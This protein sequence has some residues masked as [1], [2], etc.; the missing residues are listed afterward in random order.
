MIDRG[1]EYYVRGLNFVLRHPR[2]TIA[3][4]FSLLAASILLISPVIRREFFPEVDGGAFQ[5][6]VRAPSG[7]RIEVTE[8]RIKAVEDYLRKS[9]GDDLELFISELGVTPDWS[10]AYTPNA[11]PMDAIVRVQ[12]KEERARSAQKAAADVR[13]GLTQDPAF[14]D[15]EFSFDT[16]GLIRGA[17]NEGKSTPINIRVTGKNQAR[18]AAEVADAMRSRVARVDGIVDARVIQRLN[19]PEFIVNVDRAKAADLGLTQ[20]DARS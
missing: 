4:G 2:S 8:Q 15:L 13:E 3:V 7:T 16:G 18:S 6:T 12:L 10:A 9:L 11:G 14:A 20:D 19:Y 1:I 5:M 17:L